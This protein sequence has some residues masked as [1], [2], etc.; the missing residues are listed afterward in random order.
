MCQLS[1]INRSE[2]I[3]TFNCKITFY[4]GQLEVKKVMRNLT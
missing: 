3:N 4:D 2:Q 1:V